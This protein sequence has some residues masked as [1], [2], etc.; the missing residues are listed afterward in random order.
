MIVITGKGIH[1]SAHAQ[2]PVPIGHVI[3][4]VG[5]LDRIKVKDFQGADAFR[6][7]EL[8]LRHPAP[9][10]VVIR[11]HTAVVPEHIRHFLG[12]L[13][14]GP[15]PKELHGRNILH[16]FVCPKRRRILHGLCPKYA[17]K[18]V[19]LITL[20]GPLCPVQ[21]HA[22]L[23][24]R[25][26]DKCR[27]LLER[28]YK[29]NRIIRIDNDSINYVALQFSENVRVLQGAF[30]KL[31]GT[32]SID[33]RLESID[34]EYTKHALAGLV[35]T[36]E[37]NMVNIESIQN[38]VSSYFNIKKQDLL[39]KKRKAQFAFPRQ[40]AM[41]LCRDMINESYPQIAAAFSRDHTTI[42]HA[43]DKITKEIEKNEETKRMVAEIKQKLT[44][45]G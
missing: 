8:L 2:H 27:S 3:P 45:C 26:Y 29:K 11:C 22:A 44:T 4:C 38:F 43:Y 1:P 12:S 24:G 41:Y 14:P 7:Y 31:I 34:L 15:L 32:A 25:H 23:H 39:G 37:V 17:V 42:L 33:Q 6:I 18:M 13:W 40:I 16:M 30:T 28:E 21:H 5:F 35:H 20:I 10:R 9:D 36:E 19:Y